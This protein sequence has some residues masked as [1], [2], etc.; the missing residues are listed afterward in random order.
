M[1]LK[2]YIENIVEKSLSEKVDCLV[3]E[4]KKEGVSEG[5]SKSYQVTVPTKIRPLIMLEKHWPRGIIVR[6]FFEKRGRGKG[7]EGGKKWHRKEHK[8]FWS[9]TVCLLCPGTVKA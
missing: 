5:W 3:V 8:T 1:G 4:L 6:N 9:R 7:E 2:T